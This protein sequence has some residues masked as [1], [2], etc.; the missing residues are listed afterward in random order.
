ML[1][2]L[3][4]PS[5]SCRGF[6]QN[7]LS[8][9]HYLDHT[10]NG[11]LSAHSS[12]SGSDVLLKCRM[13]IDSLFIGKINLLFLSQSPN[14]LHKWDATLVQFLSACIPSSLPG[15]DSDKHPDARRRVVIKENT[16]TGYTML[17]LVCSTD[18]I[19]KSVNDSQ[20]YGRTFGQITYW[21]I[22]YWH[23]QMHVNTIFACSHTFCHCILLL[24]G[25]T[26]PCKQLGECM[27]L[28]VLVI[29][30]S[31]NQASSTS[32]VKPTFAC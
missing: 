20:M 1:F 19:T 24:L 6:V 11:P 27:E 14:V 26:F 15:G 9:S 17:Q 7:N 32:L 4:L 5:L 29:S 30:G 13:E 16:L 3:T 10:F 12:V 23:V 22:Q 18:R 21:R 25:T 31:G 8:S 2:F 28:S